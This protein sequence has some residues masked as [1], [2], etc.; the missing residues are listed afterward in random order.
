[1][2]TAVIV[3]PHSASGRTARRWPA[4]KAAL[5]ARIGPFETRLT[6][7]PGHA[8]ELA[9]TLLEAGYTRIISAGGDGTVHEIVNGLLDTRGNAINP[10]AVLAVLPLGTGGDF[11]RTL[12]LT[13]LDSA[14]DALVSGNTT[15][16]DVGHIAYR[17]HAGIAGSRYF[18]NLVSFGMGGEV[19]S[20][21]HNF[22]SPL[23]GK[24]AFLYATLEVFFRYRAKTV[25]LQFDGNGEWHTVRVLN[26]AAGNGRF[27]GGGM[28]VCPRAVLDDGLLE[29]TVIDALN[30]FVLAKDLPV[31]YSD[32]VYRHPKVHHFRATRLVAESSDRTS[33]EVDGEPLGTLPAEIAILPRRLRV[34]GRAPAL[35]SRL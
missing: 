18:A 24:L 22:L 26:V 21:S 14:I 35:A 23:G 30:M 33:I 12:G 11:R 17:S 34:V 13:G 10:E 3:N 8:T 7:R 27:H 15:L 9:R 2:K 31:L 32:D 6:G 20:R 28:H 5:E 25:R 1:M 16:I 19:A 29:V 4:A